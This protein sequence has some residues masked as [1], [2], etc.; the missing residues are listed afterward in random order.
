VKK[1]FGVIFWVGHLKGIWLSIREVKT[2]GKFFLDFAETFDFT[3]INMDNSIIG[4][5]SPI[6]SR[7]SM[8]H[9]NGS[10]PLVASF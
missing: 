5:S 1:Y 3:L 10:S 2:K 6:S 4:C 9:L 8:E 7:C